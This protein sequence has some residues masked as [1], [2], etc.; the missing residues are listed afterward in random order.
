M[1]Q[2]GSRVSKKVYSSLSLGFVM[3]GNEVDE[4]ILTYLPRTQT[5]L[6][7]YL[8]L[9]LDIKQKKQG[10]F[11]NREYIYIYLIT[12]ISDRDSVR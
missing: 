8:S 3:C 6:S 2:Y 10:W 12:N 1:I 5:S 11:Y 9:S 7:L 4:S